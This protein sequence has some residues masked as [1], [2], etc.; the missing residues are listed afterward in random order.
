MKLQLSSSNEMT[1]QLKPGPIGRQGLFYS[2]TRELTDL[3]ALSFI[4]LLASLDAHFV[5]KWLCLSH[6]VLRDFN[7]LMDIWTILTKIKCNDIFKEN[8]NL[9]IV[10]DGVHIKLRLL[11]GRVLLLVEEDDDKVNV[12]DQDLEL[13]LVHLL[14]VDVLVRR[15]LVLEQ[16]LKHL[17][18]VVDVAGVE[19]GRGVAEEGQ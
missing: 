4:H 14:E 18:L 5:F 12:V 16:E 13:L 19:D 1:D 7:K 15:V 3:L 8:S 2:F 11:R 6:K 17:L 10:I 9:Q